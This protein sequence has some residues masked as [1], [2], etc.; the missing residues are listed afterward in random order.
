M[1]INNLIKEGNITVSVSVNDLKEF[2]SYITQ[3]AKKELED[4][5]IAQG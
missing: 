1:F 3:Q 2:A 4:G 5:I